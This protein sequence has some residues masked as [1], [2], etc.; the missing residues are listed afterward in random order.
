MKV[1]TVALTLALIVTLAL[2]LFVAPLVAEA[3]RVAAVP[4]IG[5]LGTYNSP[6]WEAFRQGLRDLGYVDGR[7][8]AIEYRW[9]EGSDERFPDFAA[10]LVRLKVDVIVTW[11]TP[12]PLAA[13]NATRTIPIVMASS[14]DPVGT[15]LVAS[16][17]RPGGNITGLSSLNWE[18]EGKRLEL[19]KEVVPGLSR[20]A[21]LWNPGN[22]L[23]RG[24]LKETQAV[25]KSLKVQL[26][27]VAAQVPA[28]FESAFAKVTRERP[29][30]LIVLS[31]NFFVGQRKRIVDFTAKMRVPAVYTVSEFVPAGGLMSYGA[32]YPD[33]FRPPPTWTR[34]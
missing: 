22:P 26:Q 30:A 20:V 3:Q 15:G 24:L 12:A 19:L 32:S 10:E 7:T 6:F 33:L 16:L 11:G 18:L 28:D 14:G 8:I 17:A 1:G 5:V 27:L 4:R 2:G 25:A 9:T 13:K 29:D 34:S 21:V 31:D 23:H